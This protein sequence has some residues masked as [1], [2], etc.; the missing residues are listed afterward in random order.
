[1]GNIV[2][3]LRV[4]IIAAVGNPTY[5]GRVG[6]VQITETAPGFC[7]RATERRNSVG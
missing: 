7:L 6:P 4:W 2:Y 1:M 5:R 3:S